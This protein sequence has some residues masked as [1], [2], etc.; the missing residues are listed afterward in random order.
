[1][2]K[3]TCT[4]CKQEKLEKL[5]GFRNKSE[6]IRRA[7]CLEC[8][9]KIKAK[10]YKKNKSKYMSAQQKARQRNRDF[11]RECLQNS[12]CTDCKNPDWRLLE[13]DHVRGTK[14][15]GI[16]EMCFTRKCSVE[17]IQEEI[18]KCD[19]VCANCHRLRSYARQENCYK[20]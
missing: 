2:E 12:S 18:D 7:D 4:K 6:G 1:M 15:A 20:A 17:K 10:H 19:I 11:I 14:F 9:A 5:F 16:S 13:F 8:Y 3:R